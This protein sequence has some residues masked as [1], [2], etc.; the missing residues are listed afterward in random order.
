[1]RTHLG[2]NFGNAT[3]NIDK[4]TGIRYGVISQNTAPEA[5][6]EIIQHGVDAGFNEWI[7]EH[8]T[9]CLEVALQAKS[10]FLDDSMPVEQK[11]LGLSQ[12]ILE[13]IAEYLH[14]VTIES[15]VNRVLHSLKQDLE[16]NP[17]DAELKSAIDEAI[18]ENLG[19]YWE[20]DGISTYVYDTEEYK[21]QSCLDHDIFILKSPYY[22][23]GQYCS[24]C[25]PGAINCECEVDIELLG[26]DSLPKG[27]CL[28]HDFFSEAHRAPYRV[29]RVEDDKE[30]IMTREFQTCPNCQG[31]GRDTEKRLEDTWKRPF[32]IADIERCHLKDHQVETR[33]FQCF[34]CE[35]S[36]K[37]EDWQEH[38]VD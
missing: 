19:D 38:V 8:K 32:E 20:A 25:V 31:T 18:D 17:T 2:F 33:D 34:R 1:M 37:L 22:M 14:D 27:Y 4:D 7:E 23:Y 30:L 6:E 12:C 3:T 15:C 28:G 21:L 13:A 29:F 26:R 35:G 10:A 11:I 9:K 16:D 5:V 36:G 24:P